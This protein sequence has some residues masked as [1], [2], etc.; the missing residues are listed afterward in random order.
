M[1]PSRESIWSAVC[2]ANGSHAQP[3]RG[4]IRISLLRHGRGRNLSRIRD[5]YSSDRD[6]SSFARAHKLWPRSQAGKHVFCE[7]PLCLTEEELARNCWQPISESRPAKVAADGRLQ[8]PLCANGA[9]DEGIPRRI[10]E[11]LALHY[12]VNAGYIPPDH[13]VNDPRTGRRAHSRRGLPF[14]RF[15]MFPGRRRPIVEVQARCSRQ[16]RPI[17]RRQRGRLAAFCKWLARH[18]Q[19]SRER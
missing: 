13:W 8:S 2:A 6:S 9:A 1:K 14:R 18:D 15:A 4:Q 5:K 16:P 19:L 7:K 12:R 3:R 17:Q 11:P 10:H